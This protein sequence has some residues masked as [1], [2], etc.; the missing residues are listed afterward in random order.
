MVPPPTAG[1]GA[2]PTATNGGGQGGNPA[3]AEALDKRELELT[4]REAELARREA[5]LAR[6]GVVKVAGAAVETRNA[7]P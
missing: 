5:A 7:G 2:M 3:R 4:R 6:G 1:T